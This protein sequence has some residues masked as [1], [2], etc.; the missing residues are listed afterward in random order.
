V[1][2]LDRS[3]SMTGAPFEE[4]KAGVKRIVSKLG[5]DD[6]FGLV[7]FDSKAS[8]VVELA[9]IGERQTIDTAIDLLG[10][11]GGTEFSGALDLARQDLLAA[12]GATRKVVLFVTDGQAPQNGVPDLVQQMGVENVRISTI[13]LG[14]ATDPA[15]LRMIADKTNGHMR[16]VEAPGDLSKNLEEELASLRR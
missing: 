5:H 11:G 14:S 1:V 13:G 10:P 15:M 8:R 9:P 2:V 7:A 6:C 12:K 16:L 3:G 4:A